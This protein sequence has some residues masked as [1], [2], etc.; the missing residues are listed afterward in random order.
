MILVNKYYYGAI[1]HEEK[2]DV[3]V[4]DLLI[5]LVLT[6]MAAVNVFT[7]YAKL[8]QLDLFCLDFCN[9]ML[10]LGVMTLVAHRVHMYVV[11]TSHGVHRSCVNKW[12]SSDNGLLVFKPPNK[13]R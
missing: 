1:T 11:R 6:V 5:F 13:S 4:S 10:V 7:K 2:C 3:M 9:L 12:P 8:N